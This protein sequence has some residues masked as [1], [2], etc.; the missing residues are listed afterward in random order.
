MLQTRA[1]EMPPS[2][3]LAH[4]SPFFFLLLCALGQNRVMNCQN[5]VVNPY[6]RKRVEM[7]PTDCLLFLFSNLFICPSQIKKMRLVLSAL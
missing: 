7:P 3:T 6:L 2:S 5:H 1:D 4:H